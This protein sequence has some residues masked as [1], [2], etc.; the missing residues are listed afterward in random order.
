MDGSS[1]G[2]TFAIS[3]WKQSPLSIRTNSK[4][5]LFHIGPKESRKVCITDFAELLGLKAE[6]KTKGLEVKVESI[7]PLLFGKLKHGNQQCFGYGDEPECWSE[8]SPES[9]S[10]VPRLQKLI[11]ALQLRESMAELGLNSTDWI[12]ALKSEM[13]AEVRAAGSIP[14]KIECI[15]KLGNEHSRCY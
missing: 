12:E 1:W 6:N 13:V 15:D 11:K 10:H 8:I 14:F 4:Y 2:K 9:F 5:V 3:V 7:V